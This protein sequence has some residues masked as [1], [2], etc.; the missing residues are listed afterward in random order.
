MKK[1]TK[2]QLMAV[3]V[4]PAVLEAVDAVAERQHR[5][6]SEFV[7]QALIAELEKQGLVPVA[8]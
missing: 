8:A 5:T 4:P 2:K 7:R 1:P 6:R 3:Q